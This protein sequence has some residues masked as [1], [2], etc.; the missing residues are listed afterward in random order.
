MLLLIDNNFASSWVR[1]CEWETVELHQNSLTRKGLTHSNFFLQ[2]SLLGNLNNN[3]SKKKNLSVIN[4]IDNPLDIK[5]FKTLALTLSTS[6]INQV[7]VRNR[8]LLII[9]SNHGEEGGKS[10]SLFLTKMF[11][12]V[13]V[14]IWHKIF[15]EGLPPRV[16]NYFYL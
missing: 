14:A 10:F 8:V 5:K 4:S 12:V 6:T 3:Y 2:P 9:K 11:C 15:Q 7:D 1:F 13:V 16:T